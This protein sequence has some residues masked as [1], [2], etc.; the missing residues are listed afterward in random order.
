M[1]YA[2]L[3]RSWLMTTDYCSWKWQTERLTADTCNFSYRKT[4]DKISVNK[5]ILHLIYI[6]H[7]NDSWNVLRLSL[8]CFAHNLFN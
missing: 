7:G 8:Q 1:Y 2:K 3:T 6:L 4:F 5:N